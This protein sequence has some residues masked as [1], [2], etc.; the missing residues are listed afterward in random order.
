MIAQLD[1]LLAWLRWPRFAGVVADVV[2]TKLARSL[3]LKL[4]L[5]V[6]SIRLLLPSFLSLLTTQALVSGASLRHE[7]FDSEPAAWEGVN[8]RGSHFEP[9]TVTQDFGYSS[10]SHH[11]GLKAGEVGGIINP[12]AEAA[13]YG[14]RLPKS[15]TLKDRLEAS[16][17]LFVARGPG[18]FLLGFFNTNTLNEWRTP[19]TLAARFNG[20][21]EGFLC[22]L[23]YCTSRWRA[24]A[25]L[26]SDVAPGPL[27][28]STLMPGDKIYN[29]RLR[30]EPNEAAGTGVLTLVLN[31]QTNSCTV[32]KEHFTD[33][34]TFN[35]FG[36]LP[37]FKSWDNA[38][39]AW[40]AD[41][42]VN[43]KHF[44]FSKDPGW[45]GVGNRSTYTTRNIRP[46]FDFGW[47]RTHWAGG[48]AEGELGGL[49]FRG[50][51]RYT[52]MVAAYGDRIS[53]LNLNGPIV[54]RG[55]VSM[56][57]GVT[58]ST[59]SIGF[60]HSKWSLR[61]NPAQDQSIPMD[62]LGINIEGPSSEGFYFYPVYRVHE[63][64]SKTQLASTGPKLRIHPDRSTH[65]WA[66]SYDPE[67]A[68]G[69]G[70]ITVTLDA[71]ACTLD[72]G[73][74]DRGAGASFDRF[75]ICTSWIDGNSVTVF[76]DDL[77]YTA[78]PRE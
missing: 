16:G 59:A 39:E 20:R 26:I 13:Y 31:D 48:K 46:H 34:A 4:F 49:I 5:D 75:G 76:F 28:D 78:E 17:R 73:P 67:G 22:H 60:Y 54:A 58:D 10:A 8:N 32:S 63:G 6:M 64:G 66:L 56:L 52:N 38:G 19:N 50:D 21:G 68:G 51:C 24:G 33:G 1:L 27:F 57:R 61:V 29:W 25:P 45:E 43:G 23:E 12:A 42:T 7:S 30:Y 77:E 11:A 44:D 55:K 35:H 47:S 72:L 9:R 18:H 36:L 14:F 40:I 37:V 71:Q 70:R 69:N 15:L 41:V 65:D 62:Y 53:L 2:S 3:A 74:G